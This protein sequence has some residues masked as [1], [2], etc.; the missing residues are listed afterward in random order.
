MDAELIR[1][2]VQ[3]GGIFTEESTGT[4]TDTAIRTTS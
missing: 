1:Y 4:R 3:R 2:F